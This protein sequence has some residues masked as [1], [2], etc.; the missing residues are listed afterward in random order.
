MSWGVV[1][2][3]DPQGDVPAEDFLDECPSKVEATINAVL[4]AVR[5]APPP[6]FSGGGSGRQCPGVWAATTRSA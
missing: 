5:E 1:Y 2:Y 6:Q 4:Q 3:E